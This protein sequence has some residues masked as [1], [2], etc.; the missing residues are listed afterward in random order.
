[1]S[2][3]A[4]SVNSETCKQKGCGREAV[5]AKGPMA[6]YCSPCWSAIRRGQAQPGQPLTPKP[7]STPAAAKPAP[8]RGGAAGRVRGVLKDVEQAV[9]ELDRARAAELKAA[10]AYRAAKR[11]VAAA[12]QRIAQV[13]S[14]LDQAIA[15]GPTDA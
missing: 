4:V 9:V 12:E 15:G 2:L 13:R 14:V 6:G 10:D 1:M 5:Y 3:V 11:R 8:P 7:A